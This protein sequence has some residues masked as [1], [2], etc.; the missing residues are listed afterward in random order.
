VAARLAVARQRAARLAQLEGSVAQK[1]I[2]T[3]RAEADGL[4]RQHAALGTALGGREALRA[5][6]AGVVAA[7]RCWPGSGSRPAPS[8]S[9]WSAP[10][11]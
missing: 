8:C 3:A 10:T 5:P 6:L 11:A 9:S 4:A 7:A 2:D 1:D